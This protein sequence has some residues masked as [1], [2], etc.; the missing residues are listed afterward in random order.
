MEVNE[1]HLHHMAKRL[2]HSNRRFAELV[3]RFAGMKDGAIQTAEIGAG[4]WLGGLIEGKT[5]GGTLPV[6]KFV[7]INLGLGVGLSV[8]GLLDVLP[9]ASAHLTNVGAGLIGSF[10]S[11]KG[12]AWGQRWASTGS[13]LPKKDA[14]VSGAYMPS[15]EAMAQAAA[16]MHA[17]NAAAGG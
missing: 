17:A 9:R 12:Y 10:A 16:Q 4:A 8:L 14:K 6:L 3:G 1:Q 2:H 13:F 7:P 11:A 15:P 5:N